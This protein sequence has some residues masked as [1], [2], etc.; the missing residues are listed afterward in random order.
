MSFEKSLIQYYVLNILID[1]S[2]VCAT[3]FL[4]L[5]FYYEFYYVLPSYLSVP[6]K[7]ELLLC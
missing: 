1:H 4:M 6:V 5:I 2:T 3:S 7:M